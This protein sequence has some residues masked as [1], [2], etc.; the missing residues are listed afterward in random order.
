MPGIAERIENFLHTRTSRR[1]FLK[2]TAG[3]IVAAA[4]PNFLS[5]HAH[6][7][8]IDAP[9]EQ[10]AI[11]SKF[12][13]SPLRHSAKQEVGGKVYGEISDGLGYPVQGKILE[14]YQKRGEIDSPWGF[15]RTNQFVVD[16]LRV[17]QLFQNAL[18]M[19]ARQDDGTYQVEEIP[20]MQKLEEA[21]LMPWVEANL[22]V[23]KDSFQIWQAV[24]ATH[25][26]EN[27]MNAPIEAYI[28]QSEDGSANQT[29]PARIIGEHIEIVNLG[30]KHGI[31]SA[32]ELKSPD[33]YLESQGVKIKLITTDYKDELPFPVVGR[34]SVGLVD[35]IHRAVYTPGVIPTSFDLYMALENPPESTF[36]ASTS[37]EFKHEAVDLPFS[38]SATALVAGVSVFKM[39]SLQ[40][41]I[42][43]PNDD[44]WLRFSQS[45]AGRKSAEFTKNN[46]KAGFPALRFTPPMVPYL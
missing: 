14:E 17:G 25:F 44:T 5:G 8:E 40:W 4:T 10:E 46:A 12:F 26:L 16:E 9:V 34:V 33:E 6:A 38:A 42:P 30:A 1:A 31:T 37:A 36:A 15:V 45:D 20:V 29:Y 43:L 21:G 19:S 2:G 7:Q 32:D 28:P 27:F 13:P 23:G 11:S 22:P 35:Q 3:V 39:P 18:I 41:P 24:M